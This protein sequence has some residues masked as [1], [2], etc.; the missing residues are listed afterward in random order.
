MQRD[1][2]LIRQILLEIEAHADTRRLVAIRGE[3]YS[4][5]QVAYHVKL[6]YEA[7]LIDA[8]NVSG[9]GR[10]DWRAKSLTWSGHEFLDATRNENVWHRVKAE[11]KDR[12]LSLPFEL[13]KELAIKLAAAAAG[14]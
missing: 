12:G 1:V 2:D 8:V 13:V 4:S 11:L 7:G 3:G 10:L 14:L 9:M 6:L 5:E